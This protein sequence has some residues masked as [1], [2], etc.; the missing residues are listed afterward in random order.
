MRVTV[1]YHDINMNY[2]P[3]KVGVVNGPKNKD[4]IIKV[5]EKSGCIL[6]W[7]MKRI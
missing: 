1:E 6:R 3:I 2:Q 7:N 5:L 4:V